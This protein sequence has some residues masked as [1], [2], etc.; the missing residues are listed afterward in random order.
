MKS[1]VLLGGGY[2]NMGIMPHILPSAL[3]EPYSITLIVRMPYHGLQ[4]EF[5]ACT[6]GT[7]SH[8]DIHMNVPALLLINIVY[9]E[10][11]YINLEDQIIS[12]GN[13]KVDYDELVIGLGCEDKY[14]NVPGAAEYTH[15]IQ[16]LSSSRETFHHIS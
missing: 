2:G 5:S 12:V 13:T 4:P 1:L 7:K 3:P 11:N 14:H 9:G 6:A 8:Q 16:T 15:S 10:I